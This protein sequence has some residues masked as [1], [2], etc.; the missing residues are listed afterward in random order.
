MW[1]AFVVDAT[2]LRSARFCNVLA[3][4]RPSMG[5]ADDPPTEA[6]TSEGDSNEGYTAALPWLTPVLGS[7]CVSAP[8]PGQLAALRALPDQLAQSFT[9]MVLPDGTKT[10]DVLRTFATSLLSDR[11]P[12]FRRRGVVAPAPDSVARDIRQPPPP[13]NVAVI[14]HCVLAA[15][16][17]TTAWHEMVAISGVAARQRELLVLPPTD[18][19]RWAVIAVS[20]LPSALA[21]LDLV[22][23]E[24][25]TR[26]SPVLATSLAALRGLHD[27]LEHLLD[28]DGSRLSG[29]DISGLV[30]IAWL[31]MIEP[32]G[33][34]PGWRDLMSAAM[35]ASNTDPSTG[36]L[37]LSHPRP[38]LR[39][40]LDATTHAVPI[41]SLEVATTHS[42]RD[43]GNGSPREAFY[44][45]IAEVLAVQRSSGGSSDPIP[46][47]FI[48]SMDLELEMA[49]VQRGERFTVVV[50]YYFLYRGQR[51]T[52]FRA[53]F[54]WIAATIDPPAGAADW[55]H[56]DLRQASIPWRVV[57]GDLVRRTNGVVVVRLV[58]SPLMPAAHADSQAHNP[59]NGKPF[60]GRKL[61]A[62]LAE[63]AATH[64]GSGLDTF[65]K[66]Y[67]EWDLTPAF[68]LDEYSG[69]HQM[70]VAVQGGLPRNL[71]AFSRTAAFRYWLAVGVQ[72]DDPLIRMVLAS[73]VDTSGD[74]SNVQHQ[75][76]MVNLNI[77][78]G[79]VDLLSWQGF[80]AVQSPFHPLTGDLVH[81]ADHLRLDKPPESF[82]SGKAC[83][84]GPSGAGARRGAH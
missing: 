80:D 11:I 24:E 33:L 6:D 1:Q 49:L 58:G 34:Y 41:T 23:N 4:Y 19:L 7:G 9:G 37:D 44:S 40:L 83:G 13:E 79:E 31:L 43:R 3:T 82:V 69:L 57:T 10:E 12:K 36:L 8:D 26:P 55:E 59:V 27:K 61:L 48:T 38:A 20:Q 2:S 78:P 52:N 39:N 47:A 30:E 15:A 14:G 53:M 72:I 25:N 77:T 84:V 81:Y 65:E 71:M 75:G 16:L 67:P 68:L 42:W 46:A 63:L 50:P 17:L 51:E 54:F 73:Q 60:A 28:G 22:V 18:H 70:A 21:S 45:G 32:G 35:F 62:E 56:F 5:E 76:V 29:H 74:G 66:S 64:T